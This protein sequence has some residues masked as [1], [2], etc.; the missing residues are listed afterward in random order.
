M[1]KATE[2]REVAEWLN[3]QPAATSPS[4]TCEDLENLKHNVVLAIL[5]I[6]DILDS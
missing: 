5:R 6:A 2:L 3:D 4:I 1:D